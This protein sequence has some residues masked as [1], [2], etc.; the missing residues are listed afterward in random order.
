[1][2]SILTIT[3]N[4]SVDF[5]S[6]AE[7]VRPVR[8]I[9]TL[10][11]R[12]DPGGGGVNVARIVT[13]LGG[14]AEAVFLA[15]GATGMLLDTLLGREGIPRRPLPVA[16]DTRIAFTVFER[17][18]GLDYRFVPTGFAV[19]EEELRPCLDAVEAHRGGYVVASGSLPQGAPPDILAR[20]ADIAAARGARFVLD[21]SGEGLRVTLEKSRVFLVKPSIGELEQL[22]GRKLDEDGMRAAA[23]ELVSRGAAEIV[24]VTM[25]A[26]GAFLATASGTLRVAA[27][28]VT[29]RSAVGAGDS[30]VGAMVWALAH[31]WALEGAF[32]LG[33]A[34]GAAAVTTPGTQLCSGEDI[35]NLYPM[36]GGRP[37]DA[38]AGTDD[39]G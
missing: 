36:A 13:A 18:S 39:R 26:E 2:T 4:P 24:A 12:R 25:G 10:N 30:F 21:S 15:G 17:S 35:R 33:I 31:D 9:R 23:A 27:P 37:T 14:Q 11:E 3:L 7:L 28:R 29:V 5:F 1:M 19:R 32:R 16:A 38:R 20:M 34:A 6:E 22:V 8:K